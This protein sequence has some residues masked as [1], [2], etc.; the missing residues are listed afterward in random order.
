MR[1]LRHNVRTYPTSSDRCEKP[2]DTKRSQ[3]SR[4]GIRE[5]K[6]VVDSAGAERAGQHEHRDAVCSMAGH[7]SDPSIGSAGS[8]Q[9]LQTQQS[10]QGD[11]EAETCTSRTHCK[12]LTD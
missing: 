8:D 4:L 1:S 2:A 11:W 3:W 5:E 6:A 9:L 7:T 10:Q 12:Q